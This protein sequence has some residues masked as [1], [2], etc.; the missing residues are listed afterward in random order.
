M[1]EERTISGL[2]FR[3]TGSHYMVRLNEHNTLVD[4][5]IRGRL[6]L[7][8][9]S[10]TNPIAVGDH[11]HIELLNNS[12]GVITAIEPRKNYIIRR[13]TNLSREAHV[14]AANL[15]CAYLVTTIVQPVNRMEFIDRF[16]VTCE[17]YKVPVKILVNKLDLYDQAALES[18]EHFTTIYS[19]AGYEVWPVSALTGENIEKLQEDIRQRVCLFSGSSGVGKSSLINAIDPTLR[20]RTGEIS[21]YHQKGMHTTTFYEMFET[22]M[23]GYIIDTP[24]IKGFGLV[25]VGKEEIYHFFPEIFKQAAGCKFQ[26]CTHTHEPRCAVLQAVERGDISPERYESYL[27]LLEDDEGKYR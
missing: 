14:I 12:E 19:G 27:K 10:T 17:A 4:C 22:A 8:E 15:D 16:L 23:G 13:S 25:D 5:T 6:R 18:L 26:P 1:K 11:V 9:S 2:V 20:L 3:H 24:G 21:S 7:K